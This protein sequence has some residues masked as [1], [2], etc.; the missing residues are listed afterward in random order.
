M[1]LIFL[2]ANTKRIYNYDEALLPFHVHE[3]SECAKQ[4]HEMFRFYG[5]FDMLFVQ[6]TPAIGPGDWSSD[7][8][9]MKRHTHHIALSQSSKRCSM[10]LPFLL[11]LFVLV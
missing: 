2:E 1:N 9:E 10:F 11:R 6:S 3:M 8:W 7:S 5:L 4:V